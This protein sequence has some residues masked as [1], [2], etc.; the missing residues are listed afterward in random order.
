MAKKKSV[1]KAEVLQKKTNLYKADGL[2]IEAD[3]FEITDDGIAQF[4]MRDED[5]FD[6]ELV[7]VVK[8]WKII[9][10]QEQ[11]AKECRSS[12]KDVFLPQNWGQV[13]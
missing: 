12:S 2:W 1:Q 10:K 7:T 13:N 9:A 5:D 8:D 4:Y 3:F 11:I 6:H